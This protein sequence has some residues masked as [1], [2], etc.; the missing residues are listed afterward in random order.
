[1]SSSTSP[2]RLLGILRAA[3]LVALAALGLGAEAS[4][5]LPET[6]AWSAKDMSD[7]SFDEENGVL[8]YAD[9]R[10][11]HI[12]VNEDGNV[13]FPNGEVAE[14]WGGLAPEKAVLPYESFTCHQGHIFGIGLPAAG[15]TSK[16]KQRWRRPQKQQEIF[17]YVR[18]S[19]LPKLAPAE[20]YLDID[21]E[22]KQYQL[23]PP[24]RPVSTEWRL[25]Y[26][27]FRNFKSTALQDSR[28]FLLGH[29]HPC[30]DHGARD[31]DGE[32]HDEEAE[33]DIA[34]AECADDPSGA[35]EATAPAEEQQPA[36]ELGPVASGT[37]RD[38]ME[39][40]WRPRAF[41]ATAFGEDAGP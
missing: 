40:Q 19:H 11:A 31:D 21:T 33:E 8:I 24:V 32:E 1:M 14:L 38:L 34:V 15:K 7:L 10:R 13:V 20:V 39:Q 6:S 16:P 26:R 30:E 3:L 35:M 41:S 12:E 25:W 37:V 28:L 17:S 27:Q 5:V 4:R 36:A 18:Q 9:G 22:L 29:R 23:C 2:A